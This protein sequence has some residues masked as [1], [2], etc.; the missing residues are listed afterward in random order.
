MLSRHACAFGVR[1]IDFIL[2][3]QIR[4]WKLASF[5]RKSEL[6]EIL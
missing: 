2:R 6:L 4:V 3:V 5:T 1:T